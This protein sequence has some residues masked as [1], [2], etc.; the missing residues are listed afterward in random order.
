MF[1][2]KQKLIAKDGR[3]NKWNGSKESQKLKAT[4]CRVEQIVEVQ[5]GY[6]GVRL[7]ADDYLLASLKRKTKLEKMKQLLSNKPEYKKA[8]TNHYG[9]TGKNL[10][11]WY[12]PKGRK[13]SAQ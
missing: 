5:H 8:N 3:K 13:V 11:G 1:V 6:N 7:R 4:I 10:A 12:A 9:K 2:K